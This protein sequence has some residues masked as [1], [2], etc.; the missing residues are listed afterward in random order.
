[1]DRAS[2]VFAGPAETL[3]I[4]CRLLIMQKLADFKT[5]LNQYLTPHCLVLTLSKPWPALIQNK[6][7][8]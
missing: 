8:N 1:M 3:S 6:I 5:T 4:A 2:T 7:I